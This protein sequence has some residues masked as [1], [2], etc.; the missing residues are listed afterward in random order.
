MK[1]G[2]RERIL[3]GVVAV[4]GLIGGFYMLALKPERQKVSG[5]DAQI[6]TARASLTTA[7]Q[8]YVTGKQAQAALKASNEEWAAIHLAVPNQSDIP[9][10]LRTL[11][12]TADAAHV[13]MQ[14]ITLSGGSSTSTPAVTTTPAATTTPATPGATAT[15]AA[16]TATPVPVQLTF[17][18]GY[19]ALDTLVRS[20]DSLVVVSHG[21]LH[22]TGPLM[23]ISTVSLTGTQKLTVQISASLYQLSTTGGQ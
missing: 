7:Q 9:A 6:A 4:V 23:S 18:G 3:V 11:Q 10:L 1:L 12:S 13:H 17:A 2:G 21:K 16:P 19:A 8:S 22:A 14:A 15:P 5:L 20:L